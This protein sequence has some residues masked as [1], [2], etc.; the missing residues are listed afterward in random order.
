MVAVILQVEK[1]SGKK[2]KLKKKRKKESGEH[3]TLETSSY[4]PQITE[5]LRWSMS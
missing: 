2:K 5:Y 4:P 1:E 3:H